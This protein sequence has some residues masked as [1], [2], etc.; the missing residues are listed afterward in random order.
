MCGSS[1]SARPGGW[2][3][4]SDL[5][6]YERSSTRSL[7]KTAA[8]H[9]ECA[10]ADLVLQDGAVSIQTIHRSFRSLQSD[11]KRNL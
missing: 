8:E 4:L 5:V 7:L 11:A 2:W 3:R 10:E 6:A 9:F 1:R